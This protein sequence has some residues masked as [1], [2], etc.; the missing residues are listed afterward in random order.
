M[1]NFMI[2]LMVAIIAFVTC[3]IL[4]ATVYAIDKNADRRD[5]QD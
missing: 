2:I 1:T 4:A 3:A 5:T